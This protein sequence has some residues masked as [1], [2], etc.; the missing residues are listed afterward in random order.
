MEILHVSAE[1]YPVAKTGGLGDVVGA[2]PKYQNTLGHIAKVVMPMHRT[3]F[4]YENEWEVTH[5]DYIKVGRDVHE[6]TIIKEKTNKLG[7]DL[8]LVDVSGVLDREKVY[9]YDDDFYRFIVFQIAVTD[10][11]SKWNHKPDIIHVHDHHAALIPFMLQNCFAYSHISDIK[12][13]LTIHNGAYQGWMEWKHASLL[14]AWDTWKWGLLD[15]DNMLNPLACGIKCAYRVTTVSQGYLQELMQEHQGIGQL[16]AHEAAKCSGI[17][18]GVDYDVWDPETDTFIL[19]NFNTKDVNEGKALNKKQLCKTFEL[20]VNRPLIIFIGRLVGEKGADLLAPALQKAFSIPNA[21]FCALVL[22]SGAKEVEDA[23]TSLNS[24]HVGYYNS[25]IA[26]NEKLSHL[27]YAGADFLLM[28]SR[29]EPC[30]LN[31]MYAMRYGTVPMVRKIGGLKDTV[32]DFEDEG[33]Y[34]ITFD[35]ATVDDIVHSIQRAIVLYSDKTK[36]Q[37]LRKKMMQIDNSWEARAEDYIK[38]YQN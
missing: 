26:Y 34:G 16:I 20:D 9:G 22:G 29:I 25:R 35:Q 36:L 23:L 2:L 21:Q 17:I 1:C 18:N 32:I 12:T 24:K 11:V 10:W 19:D 30:G 27:M 8:Y 33:G 38:L 14:P 6:C 4:L 28:P 15:W 13:V 5:K 7:F 31:Q 37:Q 3:P